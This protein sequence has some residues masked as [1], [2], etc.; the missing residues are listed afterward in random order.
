MPELRH[1]SL[2]RG[3]GNLRA[4]VKVLADGQVSHVILCLL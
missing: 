1:A 4:W 3:L 2:Q